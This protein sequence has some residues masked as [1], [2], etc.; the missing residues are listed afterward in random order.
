MSLPLQECFGSAISAAFRLEAVQVSMC[1]PPTKGGLQQREK[2]LV[3][4]PMSLA[5]AVP[6]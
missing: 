1:V 6:T 2:V 5:F 3:P 4:R